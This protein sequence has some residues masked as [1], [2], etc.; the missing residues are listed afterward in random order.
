MKKFRSVFL[1]AAAC[2]VALGVAPSTAQTTGQP[3]VPI[4]V[5]ALRDTMTTVQVSPSGKRLLVIKNESRDGDYLM[6]LYDTDN[7]GG[8]P[9]RI[10]ADPMEII[11]AQWV[12]DDFIFGTAWQQNRKKVNGPEEGTYDYASFIFDVN[13]KKFQRVEGVF[14]IATLLPDEPNEIL[15]GTGRSVGSAAEVDPFSAFRPRAYYKLNLKTGSKQLVLKGSEKYPTAV[16]DSQ[17]NPRWTSGYDRASKEEVTYYRKPGDGSWTEFARYDQ[18]DHE[19]LYRVLSGFMGLVGFKQDDP[20]IGYVIDN[21]GE[22]KASLWEFDFNKGQFGEKLAGTDQADIMWIQTSSL[23]GDDRLVAA[24][25]P[26]DKRNRIW[27]DEQEKALY[28]A[29]EAQIP[30]AHEVSISSRSRDGN[31]MIVQNRGPRDPGSFWL[32]KDGRMSK[33]GSRNPLLKAEDLSDVEFIR[34]P[35]RDGKMIAGYVTK[36]KGEGP[37]PLVVLPHGGP[38]VN[39]VISYDEWGQLLAN[40]GYMVLQPQYRMSV[41]WGKELFDSAY[42]QHG[43]AMQDD[44]DDGALYLVEQGLVD[45]DRIA[46]FGWSYGGYAALV[47]ASRDP[48]IYQCV[49]AGAA[50]ADPE[51]VYKLRSNPWTPTAIDDW[52][53]RRGMIGINPINEVSKVN[54]PLLMVHGDVDA[55][56]LYFNFEDYRDAIQKAGKTDAQ[57]LTLTGADHFYSTLMYEHQEQFYTKMLDFLA[58]DCGPGGL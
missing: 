31:T 35:A 45:P 14:S 21:R 50:V 27:F 24:R 42:G 22:D 55:R 46:M 33:L 8:K 51:K 20:N 34:Y 54:V 12:S 13:K 1:A 26:W 3:T 53:Q 6:E 29:L 38:H 32:V 10:A 7:L 58:N 37:F 47:A 44:K 19:N 41:G 43:L 56:V 48:N 39:E 40:A 18:D 25:Y 30:N 23:P 11:G 52:A 9:Y 5:W 2:T 16:F 4:E 36:P 49:I 28:D 57:F 15:I 17:G